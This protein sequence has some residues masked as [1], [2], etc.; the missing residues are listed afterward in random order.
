[1]KTRILNEDPVIGRHYHISWAK[2]IAMV[3]KLISFDKD[4][5]QCILE[6]KTKKIVTCKIHQLRNTNKYTRDI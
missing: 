5:D 2:K 1:M 4:K 3:W 6:T